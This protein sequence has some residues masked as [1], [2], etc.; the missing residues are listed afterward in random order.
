MIDVYR[1][2]TTYTTISLPSSHSVG[3]SFEAA[4]DGGGGSVSVDDT[5]DEV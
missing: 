2:G 4:G 5:T 1:E 3:C